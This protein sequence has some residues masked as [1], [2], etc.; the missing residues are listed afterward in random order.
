MRIVQAVLAVLLAGF[1]SAQDSPRV[2]K[3]GTEVKLVFAQSL[4]S[5]H[6]VTGERVELRVAQD[7]PVDGRVVVPAGTRV[8]GTV[9]TG[10]QKEKYGN[11]KVLLISF[12]CIIAGGT[13]ILLTGERRW[14]A[15]SNVAGETAATIGFGVAGLLLARSG[16]VVAVPEGTAVSAFVAE[17]V[18]LGIE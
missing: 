14:K 2:L 9:K 7:V 8:L 3:A 5:K 17:D 15:S 11:A 18:D 1:T 6:A 4:S 13:R 12:D 10:K 16:R